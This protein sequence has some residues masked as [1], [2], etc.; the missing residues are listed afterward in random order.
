M[1][2]SLE[3][4]LRKELDK[5]P[6]KI[7]KKEIPIS[8]TEYYCLTH[9]TKLKYVG[10]EKTDGLFA[11]L[12]FKCPKS[13]FVLK[14]N[15]PVYSAIPELN[16]EELSIYDKLLFK[17]NSINRDNLEAKIGEAILTTHTLLGAGGILELA[18]NNTKYLGNI[19]LMLWIPAVS[20]G[21]FLYI[22]G[23]RKLDKKQSKLSEQSI[24]LLKRILEY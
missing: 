10:H 6:C 17:V 4:Q 19:Y 12:K 16:E 13:G 1:V 11:P 8:R 15:I 3:E 22:N 20:I 18:L 14:V 24:E 21:S 5:L 2:N 23:N 9:H 7:R